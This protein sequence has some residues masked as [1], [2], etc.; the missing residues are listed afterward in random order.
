MDISQNEAILNPEQHKYGDIHAL[1]HSPDLSIYIPMIGINYC[2]PTYKNIREKA[3]ITVLGFVINGH[4]EIQVNSEKHRLGRGDVF[5]LR[6]DSRHE[7]TALSDSSEP[8][9]YYW[10]NLH[11]NSLPLLETFHLLHTSYIPDAGIGHLF[12]KGLDAAKHRAEGTDLQ[13]FSILTCTEIM[14]A[15]QQAIKQAAD[16]YS[17]VMSRM[18][19]F[20]DQLVGET[21]RSEEFALHMGLSFRQLNRIFKQHT[22]ITIYQYVLTRKMDI[23]KMMLQDT[24]M[25]V[26]DIAFH[27]GYDDPQYFSNLFKQKAGMSPT[28]YRKLNERSA[29]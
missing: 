4:G 2:A 17:P 16:Y 8:W 3:D 27:L 7:V 14:M 19:L 6:K 20:L 22:G 24:E 5:I 12:L 18:K 15:L 25:P 13:S 21:F 11:G 1:P 10:Y 29:D 9:T 28:A 26:G 23:A